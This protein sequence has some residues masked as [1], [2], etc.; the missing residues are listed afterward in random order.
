[1]KDAA[2]SA[3]YGSR[4]AYGVV[5]VKT[6]GGKEGD[7]KISYDG[8]VAVKMATYTPDVL[9]SEWYAR[10]SNEAAL[11]ENPNTS[12]LPYTDKEIQM[13]RDGSNPDMY[14]N[15]NWYDLVLKDEAVMTKHSVSFSGGNKVKYFTSL[16]YMYDDK[17]TPGA[18]SERYNLTTNISSDIKSWLTM[19]SNI[20]YI[21]STSDNDKGGV[22]YTH[23]LT[24]PS[25]Y[26]A[27]QSNGEW[28]S[29]EGGK[30]AATVNMERN[31]LRRLEEGGWSNSKTQNTLINLAL[32]IKPVKGLVLTGEMIYKAWDYKSKTYT[33]NKSKIKDF[34]TGT[35]LNGTDVTNSKMEY[36]WEE[37]SR[38]TYNALAN[39]V[40]SNEKHNVNVLAG[41]SYEH[42]K[43]Q[44]QK[45][46]RLK[47]PT[48]GMTDMN[49]GSSAPDDTY[50]EGGSNEDKLM[51][52][53]GRVNYSFMDRYLLEANIRADASSRFHKDNRW[54][55]FPSFSAGWR[56]SQEGFMQDINWI[57][58]L[59]LRA[60]WGQ[61]GN[62]N[63]VGQYDYFSS[64]QQG[65]NY[66]F[67]DAIVSGIVESKPA[68]PTLGWKLLLSLISV[69]ILTFSMDC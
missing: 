47:F 32:D 53:F 31:P 24:I 9:G 56:I 48:N 63:N 59:K 6:K 65:G 64:Y 27:R 37:N 15:T 23:L 66:N 3:I 18:K 61:L 35:E 2:S 4:A 43:Y 17:F 34:Q 22:V 33:A 46:Y 62:I 41:V 45:S 13:F 50:A 52:Y 29:Y 5:L 7:L 57:N 10:L 28:G 38:L 60:S 19:R 20:N 1:M 11:N 42:Y 49:G 25:T 30:P 40:W 67:E 14:P 26:V 12:T 8:S 54:G 58:N 44:K 51:S 68:N 39:Y 36:S 69:W 16:G 21:Q 55:V